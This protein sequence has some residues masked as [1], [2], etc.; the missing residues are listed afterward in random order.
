[1]VYNPY[2]RQS[3]SKTAW[4][5]ISWIISP[6]TKTVINGMNSDG[7][8]TLNKQKNGGNIGNLLYVFFEKMYLSVFETCKKFLLGR[9]LMLKDCLVIIRKN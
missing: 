8:T 1:M 6:W 4:S 7:I 2:Y 3:L 9:Y 5:Q